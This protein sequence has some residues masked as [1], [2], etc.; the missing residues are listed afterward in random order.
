MS[1]TPL[2]DALVKRDLRLDNLR[3]HNKMLNHARRMEEDRAE[4]IALIRRYL[5]YTGNLQPIDADARA[6]LA[7]L[8]GAR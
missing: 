7:K 8:E 3:A 4:L 1:K 2:T 5:S 6:L